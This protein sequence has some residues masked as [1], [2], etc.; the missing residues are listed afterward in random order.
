[1]L[2]LLLLEHPPTRAT[3]NAADFTRRD[4]KRMFDCSGFSASK[5]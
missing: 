5:I 4:M 1:L 2:L 3:I